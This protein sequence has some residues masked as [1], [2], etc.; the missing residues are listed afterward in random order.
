MSQVYA[1]FVP[2]GATQKAAGCVRSDRYFSAAGSIANDVGC[3]QKSA[4]KT[5]FPKNLKYPKVNRSVVNATD[6]KFEFVAERRGEVLL[7]PAAALMIK[8]RSSVFVSDC[9]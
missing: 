8:V 5:R 9:F 7:I 6:S 2:V 4:K 3:V 1:H